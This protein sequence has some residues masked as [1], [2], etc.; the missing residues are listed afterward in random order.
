MK[1]GFLVSFNSLVFLQFFAMFPEY[2]FSVSALYACVPN[3]CYIRRFYGKLFLIISSFV[4]KR[5][6]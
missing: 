3:Y 1:K 4:R 2:F 5:T 6:Q